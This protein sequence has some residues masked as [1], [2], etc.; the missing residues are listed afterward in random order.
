M[1]KEYDFSRGVRGKFYRPNARLNVPV[2]LDSKVQEFVG[3]IA[4]SRRTDVS[5]VVNRLLR[6]DMEL[7]EAAK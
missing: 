1:K 6:S 3:R 2:Y 7:V 4:E 5:A